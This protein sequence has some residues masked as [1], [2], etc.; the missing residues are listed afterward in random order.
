MIDD[1]RDRRHDNNDYQEVTNALQGLRPEPKRQAS[2]KATGSRRL[3][4]NDIYG[5]GEEAIPLTVNAS[6]NLF[7]DEI[8]R[9]TMARTAN[10]ETEE[11]IKTSQYI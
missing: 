9:K 8:Y 3:I 1:Q 6:K 2:V 5:T 7:G 11:Y 4:P 10:V